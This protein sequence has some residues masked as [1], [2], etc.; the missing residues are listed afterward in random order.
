MNVLIVE[1][2]SA[3]A[4]RLEKMLYELRPDA[5]VLETLDSVEETVHWL[6]THPAPDLLLLDIQLADGL[7]FEI[8]QH[9]EVKCPV[10]FTTAYDEHALQ[11]FKV[12][13][14]DYLLKPIKLAE[15]K[16]ALEKTRLQYPAGDWPQRL[17]ALQP[18]PNYLRRLLVRL[19]AGMRV[20]ELQEIA[21]F[22]SRD[23]ITFLVLKAGGKRY[24]VDYTLEKL[25]RLL[26]G[27]AERLPARDLDA[28]AKLAG[29]LMLSGLAMQAAG[30]SGPASGGE[31]LIS[32]YIDMTSVAF[33]ESHDFHGCQVAVGTIVT[34]RLY[35]YLAAQDPA[36]FD[37]EAR[38]AAL[39][40]WEEK[41]AAIDRDFGP[42][43][44]AVREHARKIHPT[45]EALRARLT[46][47]R[48]NWDSIIADVSTTLRPSSELEAE[49]ISAQC[50]TRFPEIGVA[51][52]RAR[53]AVV[54]SRDIR[55]RFT[56]LHLAADLGLL[57]PFADLE[58]ARAFG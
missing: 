37:I 21:Y 48:D 54:L 7:S 30:N 26:D 35:E 6:Q 24:P 58:M 57:E 42:L 41:S 39:P 5:R 55:A 23:K 12:H 47:L 11:A 9:T 36:S 27:V 2:E 28:V 31:H 4:R 10:I 51:R 20:V 50:P 17:E 19:G 53:R 32:H 18:R 22:F 49:L 45:P 25:E 52:E 13:A 33:G 43:A 15:L 8:F 38:V 1:D 46:R 40:S 16:T 29:A 14:V 34:S 3:A 44:P 56:I